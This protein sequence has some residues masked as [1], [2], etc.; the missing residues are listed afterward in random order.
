M[1]TAPDPRYATIFD[2]RRPWKPRNQDQNQSN[3]QHNW[4]A[5]NDNRNEGF[6]N[7]YN[8]R[9]AENLPRNY[10]QARDDPLWNLTYVMVKIHNIIILIQMLFIG[11]F[12]FVVWLI[13]VVGKIQEKLEKR[14]YCG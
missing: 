7:N 5:S 12:F 9:D 8:T 6:G 13:V 14:R 10:E 4:F 2:R 3:K 1:T 11:L